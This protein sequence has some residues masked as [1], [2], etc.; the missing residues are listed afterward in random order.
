MC[1]HNGACKKETGLLATQ[2]EDDEAIV[3]YI[4]PEIPTYISS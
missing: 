2:E 3:L 4:P 1:F